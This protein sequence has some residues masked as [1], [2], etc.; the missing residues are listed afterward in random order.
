MQN[1]KSIC[2]ITWFLDFRARGSLAAAVVW[3]ESKFKNQKSKIQNPVD[4]GGELR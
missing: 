1:I 4:N 3:H 2:K